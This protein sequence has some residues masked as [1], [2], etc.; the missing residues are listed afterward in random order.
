MATHSSVLAW[1]IPGTGEPGGLPSMGSHRV[2]HDWSDS[3]GACVWKEVRIQFRPNNNNTVLRARWA[4]EEQKEGERKLKKGQWEARKNQE[5]HWRHAKA[6]APLC[7]PRFLKV[8]GLLGVFPLDSIMVL[9]KNTYFLGGRGDTEIKW[10][11]CR[12]RRQK[13]APG[14]ERTALESSSEVLVSDS[15]L[16]K[17][18]LYYEIQGE[19]AARFG[20]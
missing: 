12:K 15:H 18:C 7:R 5:A 1:R 3:A 8:S 10:K 14:E 19:E 17:I 4:G 11:G 16:P 9:D 13:D 6:L 2:G 20:N